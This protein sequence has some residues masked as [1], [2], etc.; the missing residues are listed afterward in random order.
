MAVNSTSSRKTGKPANGRPPKPYADFPLTA[1][2]AGYWCKQIRDKTVYFGRWGRRVDRKL[3]RVE[4]DGWKAALDL[5]QLQVHDLQAGRTPR[6]TDDGLT[7]A[8]PMSDQLFDPKGPLGP[9]RPVG[10]RQH[11]FPV[12]A[13]VH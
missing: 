13:T 1:H 12:L 8:Q 5:Y 2:P 6:T 9:V 10:E 7:V 11:H 4:G 3:E